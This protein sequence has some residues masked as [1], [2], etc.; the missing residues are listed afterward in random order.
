[1]GTVVFGQEGYV[2]SQRDHCTCVPEAEVTSHYEAVISKYLEKY[3]GSEESKNTL[4]YME[5]SK[6]THTKPHLLFY[7]ILKKFHQGIEH[8]GT[9]SQEKN[10]PGYHD[11]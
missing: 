4:M 5:K 11:L 8:V 7:Q 3:V 1:M 6:Y 2:E 9:R 10:V